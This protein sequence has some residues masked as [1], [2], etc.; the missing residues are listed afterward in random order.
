MT[1]RQARYRNK[2]LKR[3]NLRRSILEAAERTFR[4][5]GYEAGVMS[6]IAQAAGVNVSTL[7]RYF[8]SKQSLCDEVVRRQI[9]SFWEELMAGLDQAG[10]WHAKLSTFIGHHAAHF[11]SEADL[12]RLLAEVMF[13][14]EAGNRTRLKYLAMSTYLRSAVILSAICEDGCRTKDERTLTILPLVLF[15]TMQAL[16]DERFKAYLDGSPAEFAPALSRMVAAA[17]QAE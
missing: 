4:A 2:E 6:E 10:G 7:Y 5:R 3:E 12:H 1:D 9:E 14:P 17:L 15:C 13:L 11:S 16:I 8:P